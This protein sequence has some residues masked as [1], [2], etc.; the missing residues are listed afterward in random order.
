MLRA[1]ARSPLSCSLFFVAMD[2]P[3][4]AFLDFPSL[5][6]WG[7]ATGRYRALFAAYAILPQS[8]LLRLPNHRL[9]VG[10]RVQTYP[11]SLDVEYEEPL[12]RLTLGI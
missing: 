5:R 8:V 9:Y 2:L 6:E 10:P 7:T 12:N 1:H 11:V 4:R 3:Q